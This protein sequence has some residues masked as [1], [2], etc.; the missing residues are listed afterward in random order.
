MRERRKEGTEIGEEDCEEGKLGTRRQEKTGKQG[1]ESIGF[2][3]DKRET[4]W[5]GGKRIGDKLMDGRMRGEN[6]KGGY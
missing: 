6:G 2:D 3:K 5:L 1:R 4:N